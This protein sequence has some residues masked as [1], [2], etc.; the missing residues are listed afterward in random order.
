M[1]PP[2]QQAGLARLFKYIV[3]PD[4][5]LTVLRICL[6]SLIFA[7][8]LTNV[9]FQTFPSPLSLK[10]FTLFNLDIEK[11]VPTVFVTALWLLN[12]VLFFVV[13][14]RTIQV[15]QRQIMWFLL[16]GIFLYLGCDEYFSIHEELSFYLAET[17]Q[18]SG[19]FYFAWV[20]PYG[21][22]LIA[23]SVAMIPILFGLERKIRWL[24]IA[25]AITFTSGALG[26]EMLEA[27]HFEQVRQVDIFYYYLMTIEESL[28]NAGLIILTYAL[29]LLMVQIKL[30]DEQA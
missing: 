22:A 1:T 8:A 15:K 30:P 11:N 16:G 7:H 5:N 24:L 2:V 25:A 10:A 4:A 20:I 17:L 18:T 9:W 29:R 19:F 13:W 27:N 23:L 12:A 14:G 21:I 3:C 6:I 26:L 28:E